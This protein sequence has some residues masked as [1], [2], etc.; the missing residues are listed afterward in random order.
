M[1]DIT[2][3][4]TEIAAIT[5]LDQRVVTFAQIDQVHGRPKGTAKD[6]FKSNRVSQTSEDGELY[7]TRRAR[8]T[9]PGIRRAEPACLVRSRRGV[10]WFT[11]A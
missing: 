9:C 10:H 5:Y 3:G 6:R 8:G 11:M 1:T 2:I 7:I 4:Q